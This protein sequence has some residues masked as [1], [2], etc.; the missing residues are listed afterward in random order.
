MSHWQETARGF[1][2]E[3]NDGTIDRHPHKYVAHESFTFKATYDP[4]TGQCVGVEPHMQKAH[5]LIE[6]ATGEIKTVNVG[7]NLHAELNGTHP[8]GEVPLGH[9]VVEIPA[10]ARCAGCGGIHNK[11]HSEIIPPDFTRHRGDVGV[12]AYKWDKSLRKM[13]RK[14]NAEIERALTEAEQRLA[15]KGA[16]T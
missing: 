16:R 15:A 4:A 11:P 1:I 12:N 7:F 8:F 6:S 3:N 10:T 2:R 14:S 5:A 13:E 9:E